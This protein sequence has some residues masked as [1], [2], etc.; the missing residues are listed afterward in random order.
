MPTLEKHHRPTT[1]SISFFNGFLHHPQQVGSV[2]P[3]SRYLKKHIIEMTDIS[4]A[5]TIVELGP[6]TGGTTR[7]FLESMRSDA[8]LLVIEIN[9]D[10]ISL[11]NR[12]EDPRLIRHH[13]NACD[14]IKILAEYQ[15]APPDVIVS[16]IPFSTMPMAFGQ[17]IID[18]IAQS[19]ASEGCF[20]AYQFRDR[21][22]ELASRVF[23]PAQIE[24][25]LLNIP[26]V[27]LYCWQK[28]TGHVM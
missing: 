15:L 23:G 28:T 21:V 14:L 22:E 17:A 11:L 1:E 2:I 16:G 9:P 27:H 7:S 8:I 3:S 4:S 20:L 13:G 10:F 25:E 6:G 26:P 5:K 18:A 19:L 24:F 12:I